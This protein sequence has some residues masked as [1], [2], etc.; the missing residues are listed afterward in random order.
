VAEGRGRVRF[1]V[2]YGW[3]REWSAFAEF[4][5][6]VEDLGYDSYWAPDHPLIEP[7]PWAQLAAL[8]AVT[9]RIRLGSLVSCVYY[10]SPALL[11]RQA[12]DVDRVSNGRLVLGLGLGD[13]PEEFEQIGLRFPPAADRQAALVETLHILHGLWGDAPFTFE[14]RHFQ[15]RDATVRPRPVQKPRVPILIGGAGERVTLRRVAEHAEMSNVGSGEHIGKAVNFA[16]VAHK[17]AV[18]QGHCGAI[19]RPY[20]TLVR[21]YLA[22]PVL[23]AD[24]AAA[25]RAKVD[26]LPRGFTE[27]FGRGLLAGTPAEIVPFFRGLIASGVN[28]ILLAAVGTDLDSLHRFSREVIPALGGAG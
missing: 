9:R 7:D 18:L 28:Y 23:L 14:G 24:S 12:A 22:S 5:Q 11:A 10:R 1:G 20:D 16:D 19:G 27:G 3:A 13:L 26:A 17:L 8:A 25:V 6:A 15:V 4:I 2:A 21:S